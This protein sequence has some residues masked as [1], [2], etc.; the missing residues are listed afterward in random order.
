MEDTPKALRNMKIPRRK[1]SIFYVQ[2]GNTGV[3]TPFIRA[4]AATGT[5]TGTSASYL[6]WSMPK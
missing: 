3:Q 1:K 6:S 2:V 5:G 4:H